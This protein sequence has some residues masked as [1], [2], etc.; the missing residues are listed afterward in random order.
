MNRL[1][2]WAPIP[3]R[4]ALGFG[5]I[6]HGLPKLN[7]PAVQE[8][9]IGSLGQMG[10]PEARLVGLA[11]GALELFGGALLI[12]G[13][14]TRVVSA[15]MIIEMLVAIYLVHLPHGFVSGPGEVP[16]YELNV[17]YIAGLLSLLIGGPGRYSIDGIVQRM[18]RRATPTSSRSAAEASLPKRVSPWR[19]RSPRRPPVVD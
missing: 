7:D 19:N 18:R 15:F 12:L 6:Y 11:V 3:L 2:N 5:M 1:C 13:A 10:I 9:F 4:L 8:Q 16:G 14:L 17:M